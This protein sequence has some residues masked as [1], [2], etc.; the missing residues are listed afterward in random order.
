[1]EAIFAAIA[2]IAVVHAV[3]VEMRLADI[4]R[5]LESEERS[6]GR[7]SQVW[8]QGVSARYGQ[9]HWGPDASDPREALAEAVSR[10]SWRSGGD[11]SAPPTT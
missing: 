9:T 7:L 5:R 1:M 2:L 11:S 8:W 4:T 3:S 6:T 10:N